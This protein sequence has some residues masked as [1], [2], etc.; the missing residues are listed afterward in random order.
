MGATC[1]GVG[2]AWDSAM[3]VC[4]RRAG[5]AAA[6]EEWNSAWKECGAGVGAAW[7]RRAGPSRSCACTDTL[8]IPVYLVLS[9]V[10][11]LDDSCPVAARESHRMTP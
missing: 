3:T 10:C 2:V 4:G 11:Q 6:A 7:R 9:L 8:R 1:S 5:G